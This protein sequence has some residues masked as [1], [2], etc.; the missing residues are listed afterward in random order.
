MTWKGKG[1]KIGTQTMRT[2]VS[3]SWP[4]RVWPELL[5]YFPLCPIQPMQDWWE[6]QMG[7]THG[8]CYGTSLL[9]K[10]CASWQPAS[11]L[12]KLGS[13]NCRTKEVWKR[14]LRSLCPTINPSPPC[15]WW[16]YWIQENARTSM[17]KSV[18][19]KRR[20]IIKKNPPIEEATALLSNK[21]SS[22]I[23]NLA[24]WLF[25]R[26]FGGRACNHSFP[27]CLRGYQRQK[28]KKMKSDAK[29]Q[30]DLPRARAV[31]HSLKPLVGRGAGFLQPGWEGQRLLAMAPLFCSSFLCK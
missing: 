5:N 24:I 20:K 19:K 7:F 9:G 26:L 11:G 28:R 16:L 2:S 13:L 8:L 1:N 29:D 27:T 6:M 30:M 4:T 21:Y 12:G 14:P 10:H 25:G 3:T 17:S 31:L 22:G 18:K 15:S 23:W